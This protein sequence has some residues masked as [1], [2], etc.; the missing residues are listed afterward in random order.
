[1]IPDFGIPPLPALF[2]ADLASGCRTGLFVAPPDSQR[3]PI[4]MA[5]SNDG[6]TLLYRFAS[7]ITSPARPTSSIPPTGKASPSPYPVAAG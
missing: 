2:S 7:P 6:R 3:A 1:L 4:L 5:A